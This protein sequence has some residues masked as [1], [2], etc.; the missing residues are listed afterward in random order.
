MRLRFHAVV[1]S[2]LGLLPACAVGPTYHRP[3][4]VVPAHFKEA[5][6]GWKPAEP[7]DRHDRGAWWK[8]F[9]DAELDALET[10]VA[11]ANQTVA[12]YEAA[13]RS[14]RA[15]VAQARASLFPTLGAS[16]SASRA[17]GAGRTTN[18]PA[19]VNAG[20]STVGNILDLSLDASWEPD[21][22][23]GVRR[24][25]SEAKASA[26]AAGSDLDNAK[27]AAQGLLAQYYFQL[28]ALDALQLLLNDAVAGYQKSLQLTQNRYAQGVAARPDVL[29][30]QT[31]LALAQASATEN[32]IA[33]ATYEHAIAVLV[34]QPA[35]TFSVPRVPLTAAPPPL[36]LEF[37][38]TL[39]ERR[40]DIAAAERRAAAANERIGVAIAAWFPSLTLSAS[41]G[42][43]SSALSQWLSAPHLVWSLGPQLVASLFDGG[44]RAAQTRQARAEYDQAVAN[45]RATVLAA[46]QDVEDN[47]VSLR[48]LAQEVVIQ[49][50]AVSYARQT[51]EVVMNQ[52]KAGT[53]TYLQVVTAQNTLYSA[54]QNLANIAGR[55]MVAAV[56][57]I[58]ALGGGWDP[59]PPPAD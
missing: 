38:S 2:A 35:S 28:R 12:S 41:G 37:P 56:G 6:E 54:Q 31:Q 47:L 50:E 58:K 4:V 25:L 34:G 14:A 33:R 30:A 21:L 53:V 24:Q 49:Q 26:Q 51:L 1:L 57:L 52:Y 40:P 23:G 13:Y 29:Q 16:V 17:K 55:R 44:L 48:V 20:T 42:F 32:E 5:A 10:K 7:N 46:F 43:V 22:W 36:P 27:L 19:G 18:T 8:R 45:Y 3:K 11:S 9:G 39:L 59:P 15:L